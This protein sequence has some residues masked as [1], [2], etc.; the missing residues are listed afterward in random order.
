MHP[1]D[2]MIFVVLRHRASR[3]LCLTKAGIEPTSFGMLAHALPTELT[4]AHHSK[5]RSLI[6]TLAKGIARFG[7]KLIAT[8]QTSYKNYLKSRNPAL[9]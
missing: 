4:I 9:H 8:P 7:Y 1:G 5:G 6:P 2:R 3:K